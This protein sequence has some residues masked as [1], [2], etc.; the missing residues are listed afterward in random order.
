MTKAQASK[1]FRS[2]KARQKHLL[3]LVVET[4]LQLPQLLLR[5]LPAV[6]GRRPRLMMRPRGQQQTTLLT[7]M[8]KGAERPHWQRWLT[9]A[10]H[11]EQPQ[12]MQ[13]RLQLG[14]SPRWY[15]CR[16]SR[17]CFLAPYWP[18]PPSHLQRNLHCRSRIL[19]RPAEPMRPLPSRLSPWSRYRCHLHR[20][21]LPLSF[22]HRN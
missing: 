11:P 20:W 19:I 7:A 21:P 13:C 8:T 16:P 2:S 22:R 12:T 5:L 14:P 15:R 4:M 1:Y 17:R 18:D 9:S 6:M 10:L 3:M